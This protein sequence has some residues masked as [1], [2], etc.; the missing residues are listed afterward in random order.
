M[1]EVSVPRH[2]SPLRASDV[3]WADYMN[4]GTL[5]PGSKVMHKRQDGEVRFF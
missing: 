1:D 4:A 3:E 2:R 5:V